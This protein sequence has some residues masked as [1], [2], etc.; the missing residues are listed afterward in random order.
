[1]RR[2]VAIVCCAAYLAFGFV[3]GTA[4]VHEAADHHESMRGLHLDHDH[5]G[6]ASGHRHDHHH[7]HAPT[8]EGDVGLDA[9]HVAHHEGD[10]LYLTV[11]AQR[12]LDSSPRVAP[13]MV[14]SGATIES[15]TRVAMRRYERSE[16]MRGPPEFRRTP[17][18]AP[19]A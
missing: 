4:H 5:L 10:A 13:A 8:D 7:R 16:P 18:R 19:P 11:T 9:A 17:P 6:G 2:V 12:T 14:A 3:A 1:M 15:P